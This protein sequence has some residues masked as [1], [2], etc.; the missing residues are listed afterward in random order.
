MERIKIKLPEKFN[1]STEL[2]VRV[3]DLNYGNHLGNDSVL[4]LVHEARIQFFNHLGYKNEIDIE[5][6]GII[7][8]DAALVFKSEAYLNDILI[9]EIGIGDLSRFGFDLIYRI[10]NKSTGI[11]VAHV[12][13]GI[14]F[15]DYVNKKVV[16]I[17]SAFLEKI[18][19]F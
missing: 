2:K 12:K 11:N 4:S 19:T 8:A 15:F 10:S 9:T 14:V 7:L 18:M 6:C 5:G 13:T 16:S 1:Y 3:T 17:P